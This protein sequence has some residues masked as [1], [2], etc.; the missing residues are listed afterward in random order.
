M[1]T[2]ELDR[3]FVPQRDVPRWSETAWLGSW[4]PDSGVGL[5]LHIGRCQRDLDMWWAQTMVY[6][7]DGRVAVDRS[8]GRPADPNTMGSGNLRLRIEEPGR[9]WSAAFDGAA[10]LTTTEALAEGLV[11]SGPSQPM[12]FELRGEAVAPMW[13]LFAGRNGHTQDFAGGTH[14]QQ[15]FEATGRVTIGDATYPLDGCA[16]RDHSSGTRDLQRFGTHHFVL[17]VFPDRVIHNIQV[18]M[19]DG[20]T[21]IDAGVVLHRD[22]GQLPVTGTELP[23]VSALPAEPTECDLVVSTPEGSETIHVEALHA[24]N[25]CITDSGDNLNGV[26]WRLDEDMPV[27][28]ECAARYTATDGT[29]GYGHFERSV[30]RSMLSGGQG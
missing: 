3:V 18:K 8:H 16:Y 11:G 6:L 2:A 24:V 12:R 17:I 21:M 20:T 29:V 22:G 13:D 19:P 10:E 25:M 23:V 4:N 30:R 14:T 27:L 1:Q 28:V 9:S 5:F 7:P 15:A 26:G